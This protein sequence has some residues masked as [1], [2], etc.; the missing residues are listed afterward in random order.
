MSQPPNNDDTTQSSYFPPTTSTTTQ[1]ASNHHSFTHPSF[2]RP[3]QYPRQPS[4]T[5]RLIDLA[6]EQMSSATPALSAQTYR[7]QHQQ[8]QQQS[9]EFRQVSRAMSQLSRLNQAR[10]QAATSAR[11]SGTSSAQNQI[12]LYAES[13][14]ARRQQSHQGA[15]SPA[16][17]AN[18][19]P[20]FRS[21][22]VCTLTCKFCVADICDRGMK[23][24]LLADTRVELFSTDR[25]TQGRVQLVANDYMTR[26]CQCK[27]R[28][29]AC[30][31]CGNVVGYH[32]TQPCDLCLSSCN[33]GHFWMFHSDTVAA[34]DLMDKAGKSVV[35]ANLPPAGEID[36]QESAVVCR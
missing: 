20:S 12:T 25:V 4:I 15:R 11:Q 28:D 24:I 10:Q 1:S 5:S 18:I 31:G 22:V 30:L 33:N 34:T 32:V 2:Q 7:A 14:M 17:P 36:K 6:T 27:I 16:P 13:L 19:H 9:A 29:V 8:N 23:A 26:N 3:A 35:W 21:K